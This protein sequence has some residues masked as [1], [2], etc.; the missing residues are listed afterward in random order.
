MS[1]QKLAAALKDI[2]MLRSALAGLIG[3]DTEA[4][5]H[6]MEAI[7]RTI[8][9]TDA[10]RAASINAIHALLTTMPTSQE[11]VAS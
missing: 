7:M 4:E 6:Q 8:S 11:G 1:T 9:I 5:L 3:A 2:A 10:D